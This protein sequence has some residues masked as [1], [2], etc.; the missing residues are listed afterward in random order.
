M[1]SKN[2]TYN[3]WVLSRLFQTKF[4]EALL[5]MIGKS[6]TGSQA[7]RESEIVRLEQ[8]I[9][10]MIDILTKTIRNSFPLL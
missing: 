4:F 8:R 5:D 10:N 9:A 6:E 7:L 1:T 3:K 2:A